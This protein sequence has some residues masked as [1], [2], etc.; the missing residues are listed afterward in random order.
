MAAMYIH[1]QKD[2]PNFYWEEVPM[3]KL[4]SSI[5][6]RQG[7]LIGYMG[8]LGF[9]FQSEA[10]LQ[11]HTLNIV[12]T[13]EIEGEMLSSDQV[14]SSV[15]RQLGI[16]IAGLVPS[17]R[18]VDGVVEMMLDATKNYHE[19]LTKSRLFAWHKRLFTNNKGRL[20]TGQWRTDAKGRMQVVS[21]S[22]GKEKVRFVAPE[23][24][25]VDK[26]MKI[27][28]SWFNR[29][30]PIDPL[31]KASIAHLWFVTIHPFEDGNGRIAR[32]IADLQLARADQSGQRFYSMSAQIQKERS[33]YYTALEQSQKGTLDITAWQCWFIECLNGALDATELTLAKVMLKAKFWER[34]SKL[35]LNSRQRI[36]IN[37]LLDDFE[38]KLT[39]IKWGKMAKCSHDTAL[40][41]IQDL[42]GKDILSKDITGGRST[43]YTLKVIE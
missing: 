23:A 20:K 2:W 11:T 35:H 43:C 42:I 26:E 15:A 17:N 30:I 41:D 39:T 19:P 25:D 9:S 4:L 24:K 34:F 5:K 7:R 18:N 29:D 13:S 6:H 8:A 27:F 40:R 3:I 33:D 21:G 16:E 12:K 38:G 10:L 32:A 14:R 28:F 36:M 22:I 31:L 1:E 37:K